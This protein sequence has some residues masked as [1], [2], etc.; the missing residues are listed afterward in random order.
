MCSCKDTEI[1]DLKYKVEELERK[2]IQKDYVCIQLR[3][4]IRRLNLATER[5]AWD[6]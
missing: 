2:L 3:D 5:G 4:T 1:Q 6:Y